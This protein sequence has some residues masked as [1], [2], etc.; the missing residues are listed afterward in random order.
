MKP[1][2]NAK[3]SKALGMTLV[4]VVVSLSIGCTVFAG[5]ILGYVQTSE[6]AEWSSYSLA[7]QSLAMQG[8]EQVRGAK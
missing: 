2:C 5:I 1:I 7:A 8:I 6:R 3:L 4:E